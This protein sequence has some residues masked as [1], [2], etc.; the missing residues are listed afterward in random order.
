MPSQP[1]QIPMPHEMDEPPT[2]EEVAEYARYLGMDP[3]DDADLLYIAEWALTAP[4]PDGWTVHLDGDGN[5]FF[6]SAA[7]NNSTYE[8][9]MDE[10][11]RQYY[12]KAK[13][14]RVRK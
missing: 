5:E 11:Y 2:P 9:P 12:L 7:T 10:H 4:M 6:Y 3:E 13:A 1:P 14:E 8:H